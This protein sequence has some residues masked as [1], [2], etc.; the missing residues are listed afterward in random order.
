MHPD[1]SAEMEAAVDTDLDRAFAVEEAPAGGDAAGPVAVASAEGLEHRVGRWDGPSG[2]LLRTALALV[3]F[4]VALGV[5]WEV[6]KWLAGDPWRFPAFGYE[7]RPPFRL[8][9]AQDLQ[10]PHLWDIAAA[11]LDPVQRNADQSLG[12]FLVG[13]AFATWLEAAIGFMVGTFIGVVL[14]SVFVHSLTAERAFVPYLIASQTIPIIALAPLLIEGLGRGLA[15]VV[16]IAAYLTFF[17]VTIAEMR[18]LRSPDPRAL[19]LMRSYAASRW[20]T[21]WKVRMPASMPYLFTALKIAATASVVGAIIGEDPAGTANGLGRAIVNFNQQYVTGPEK[22]W[23]TILIA[24]VAGIAFYT[25]VRAA[26]VV[27]LRHR[28]PVHL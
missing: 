14:A 27:T 10:L 13:A 20:Q 18:G 1:R 4:L 25:L 2:R 23:A 21:L 3:A 17:P 7:H 12:Q 11:L 5:V 6:F 9:Q 15:S 16:F 19:E 22:L 28:S 8:L 24:S 26:E